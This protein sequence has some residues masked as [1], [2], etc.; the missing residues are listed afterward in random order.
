M[1]KVLVDPATDQ[2]L[3]CAVLGIAGGEIVSMLQ[4]AMMG[5][6]P[7]TALHDG[8]FTHPTPAESL[9]TLFD[10]LA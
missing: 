4:I 8:V 3:G 7:Y 10:N 2:I 5:Q 6:L 1:M 9:N